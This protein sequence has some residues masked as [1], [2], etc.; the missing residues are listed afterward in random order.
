MNPQEDNMQLPAVDPTAVGQSP[1]RP[2]AAG[3][4]QQVSPPV[5]AAMP[6]DLQSQAGPAVAGDVDLIEKEWVEKAK[7]I[8]NST[9]GDPHAQS[10]KINQMKADYI[11]KRYNKTIG[12]EE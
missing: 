11:Q 8:V 5:P 9:T 10:Q 12:S 7:N 2:D 1:Q 3:Q 4:S 6:S